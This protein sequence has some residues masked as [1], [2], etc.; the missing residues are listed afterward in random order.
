ARLA[1]RAEFVQADAM[2]LPIA[3]ASV[4][5]VTMAFGIRNVEQP[6]M[7]CAELV[8]V[9][10]PG[11]RCAILEFGLPSAPVVRSLYLWYFKQILPRLGRAVSGHPAAYSYLPA[12]VGS[13]PWGESFA[14]VLRDAGFNNVRTQPL[15]FGVVY[16]YTGQKRA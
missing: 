12:S 13:F 1:N 7:A 15:T 6:S 3:D 11:G 2:C 4:D 5:G 14:R 9:L 10:R 16:L 8:R